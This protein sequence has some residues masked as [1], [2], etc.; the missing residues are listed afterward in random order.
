MNLLGVISL[1]NDGLFYVGFLNFLGVLEMVLRDCRIAWPY[2]ENYIANGMCVKII[3]GL[4]RE[5]QL[6]ARKQRL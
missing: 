1:E 2:K 3:K 4:G 6:M 5:C